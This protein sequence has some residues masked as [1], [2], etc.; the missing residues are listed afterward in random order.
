MLLLQ[1]TQHKPW[2]SG[3]RFGHRGLGTNSPRLDGDAVVLSPHSLQ[4]GC[5]EPVLVPRLGGVTTPK[6]APK[7][8]HGCAAPHRCSRCPRSQE[9][10]LQ[11]RC[12]TVTLMAIFFPLSPA[13]TRIMLWKG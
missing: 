13:G 2:L 1:P 4:Q 10:P 8:A 6:A 7:A 11:L 5:P 3:G 9:G 12:S